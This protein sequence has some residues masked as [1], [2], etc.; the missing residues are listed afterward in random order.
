MNKRRVI[1]VGAGALGSHLLLFARNLEASF[2]AIDFDRVERKNLM[3]QFHTRMGVGRNKA[4]A[5]AQT[6]QGLFGLR[7][8]EVPHRLTAE[9]VEALLGRADVVV[10]CVDNA[11]TRAL[12]QAFVGARGIPCLHGALAADGGYA[13]VMWDDLFAVDGGAPG[14]ATCEDG[15]HL[16]FVVAAASRLAIA[17]Q[18]FLEEGRRESFHLHPGGVIAIGG[19]GE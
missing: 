7:L 5:A 18:V 19:G 2:V 12:I 16:P 13:R 11:E 10:D 17:L 6:F 3:S 1:I 4:Q 14:G 15:R 8:E 9:N